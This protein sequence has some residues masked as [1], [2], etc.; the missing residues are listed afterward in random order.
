[1]REWVQINLKRSADYK[2]Y[3]PV[4]DESIAYLLMQQKQCDPWRDLRASEA[5][6]RCLRPVPTPFCS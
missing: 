4:F 5:I 3:R 1:M 2:N 6:L